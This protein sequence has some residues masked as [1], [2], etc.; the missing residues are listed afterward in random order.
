[1]SVLFTRRGLTEELT[2]EQM[3]SINF[4]GNG[5][6]I[7]WVVIDG[8]KYD[9]DVD[10]IEVPDGTVITCHLINNGL[11]GESTVVVNDDTVFTVS[12]WGGKETYDYIID[13]AVSITI[14]F[15]AVISGNYQQWGTITMDVTFA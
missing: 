11:V 1:M 14:T 7:V 4:I 9:S 12:G 13:G 5:R 3:C 10:N 15:R 2:K 8:Q 6:D